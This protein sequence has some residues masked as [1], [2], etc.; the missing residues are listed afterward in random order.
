MDL[1]SR[2]SPSMLGL[3]SVLMNDNLTRVS[4]MNLLLILARTWKRIGKGG[5][6]VCCGRSTRE[7]GGYLY[8]KEEVRKVI[9][10]ITTLG[11]QVV[12]K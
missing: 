3:G 12:I 1:N 7:G 6:V 4:I 2:E 5:G 10:K 9:S 11:D 8:A